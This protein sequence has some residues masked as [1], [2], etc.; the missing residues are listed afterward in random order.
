MC[1]TFNLSCQRLAVRAN[2]LA[3]ASCNNVANVDYSSSLCAV[4]VFSRQLATCMWLDSN[5]EIQNQSEKSLM[6]N[7][8][9]DRPMNNENSDAILVVT[10]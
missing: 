2:I 7:C 10:G 6:P 5:T 4:M 3:F 1:A 9:D 8:N